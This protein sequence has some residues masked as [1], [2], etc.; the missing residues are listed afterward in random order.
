MR[1]YRRPAGR[2]HPYI[3][4]RYLEIRESKATGDEISTIIKRRE[5]LHKLGPR[6]PNYLNNLARL[7]RLCEYR[8]RDL[9]RAEELYREAYEKTA[10]SMQWGRTLAFFYAR[11]GEP[12]KGED[13]LKRGIKEAKSTP[14]KV[15]WLVMH[16]DF[17]TMY[18]PDQALRAYN[19][20]S[21]IDPKNPLPF[22]AKAALYAKAGKWSKAIE[23]MI[24]Y[25][26]RRGEDS[27]GRKT[28]IQYR[29]NAR[30]YDKAEKALETLLDR[31]PTDAQALVLKAVLFRLRGSPAK[32][33]TIATQALE[34]HPEFATAFAVRARAYLVMGELEIAKNDLESARTLSRTPQISMELANVY[35]R[36][37]REKDALLVLKSIVAENKTYAA[38]LYKLINMQLAAKDWPN[39]ES[40]I[41]EA[42]KRFPK[43]SLYWIVEGGMWQRRNQNAKAV[44]ALEKAFELGKDSMPVVRTYLLGLMNAEQ[45][46]KALTVIDSYKNKPLWSVWVNAI[47]GR[48][49]V[50]KKQDS[51]ANELFLKSVEDARPD[52][53]AFVVTQ[54]REAYG[55]KIAI[56]RMVAWSKKKPTDW[57]VRVLVGNLCSAAITD[58]KEKL[59]TA[60]RNQYAKLAIDSYVVAVEKAKEP[61]NVAMLSNRLGKAYY[62]N[63]QPRD[64]EKAYLK[65]LEIT[66]DNHAALNNLA[67]LY[68]NDL[69]E[70]EKALP[71]VR[72]VIRLRPQ[73][74]NVLDTYGWVMGKLKR[75]AEAKKYLQRS[76]ER[77][78]EL[79]ACRYHLGWVLEQTGNPKQALKHYRLGME[80]IRPMPHMPLHKRFQDALKRLGA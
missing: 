30:Q 42:Q 60:E 66:P 15:A 58:P 46:D 13:I 26:A 16:G 5:E 17:L 24:A 38:A 11:N 65:C 59:T 2:K 12:A 6:D 69:N 40:S 35:T 76:I 10:H 54:I 14:A 72:K 57:Y 29:I 63:H 77:D 61:K 70:P 75:Y 39:A 67:Y 33:V 28:L 52:E 78:P 25:V 53:L 62:D 73:D 48:I 80:L 41:A 36:L 55:S 7:A 20:A 8:T 37:G 1:A 9:T 79:A 51:K 47:L 43:Q 3:S 21:S 74:P 23:H 18:D 49:M 22:K 31:N 45:Y 34:K 68:V 50:V 64:A 56:E 32:A 27:R 19:Q 44:S 4:R 71:Y